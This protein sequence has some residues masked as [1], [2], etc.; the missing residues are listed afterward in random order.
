MTRQDTR[1]DSTSGWDE[2]RFEGKLGAR[3]GRYKTRAHNVEAVLGFHRATVG[4][5][6]LFEFLSK[7]P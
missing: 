6:T 7:I 2:K 4:T 5:I 3:G 1:Q